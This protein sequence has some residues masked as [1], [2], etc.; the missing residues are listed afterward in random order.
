MIVY[1]F[2]VALFYDKRT[3]RQIDVLGSQ[4]LEDLHKT[5]FTAF[6]RYDEHLYSF[7]LTREP[8]KSINKIYN[9]PEYSEPCFDD[10]NPFLKRKEKFDATKTKID[11]LELS[12]KDRMYYLFDFGDEWWHEITLLS[13]YKTEKISGYP[14]IIKK[15]GDSPD[16][17][18][19]YDEE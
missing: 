3:Y 5:I 2:K 9:A 6:D 7:F 11:F 19:D 16:Q 1:R 12:E 8:Q 15:V 13:M 17:Y 4:T 10:D 14:K 18:P